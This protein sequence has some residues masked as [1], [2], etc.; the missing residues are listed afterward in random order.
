MGRKDKPGVADEYK[1]ALIGNGL[2]VLVGVFS[3]LLI[4]A[5]L[6]PIPRLAPFHLPLS[7]LAG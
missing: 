6:P 3:G 2:S 4:Q 1:V 5:F 7:H